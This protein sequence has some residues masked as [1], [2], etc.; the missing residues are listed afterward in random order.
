LPKKTP[1]KPSEGRKTIPSEGEAGSSGPPVQRSSRTQRGRAG[2]ERAAVFLRAK[3]YEIIERNFHSR[4][5]EVDIIALD[6]DTIVFTEVK[7]WSNFG[8]EELAYAI[9]ERKQRRIIETAKYFLESHRKYKSMVV[10]FDV[11]FIGGDITHLVSAFME[12]V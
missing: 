6:K 9:T 1:E 2:E 11:I 8:I 7:M 5:G 12:R 4:W 10:R 3:G